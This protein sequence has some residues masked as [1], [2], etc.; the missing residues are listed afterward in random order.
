MDEPLRL[1]YTC[2]SAEK[3][4]AEGLL[5]LDQLGASKSSKLLSKIILIIIA[6][7]MLI[8]CYLKIYQDFPG[9]P[10]L[11][12]V[13][14]FLVWAIV[15]A[16]IAR[17]SVTRPP[18]IQVELSTDSVRINTLNGQGSVSWKAFNKVW[19]TE[20]LILLRHKD[21]VV[22]IF[23][24]RIFPDE[25]SL[26]WFREKSSAGILQSSSDE[27]MPIHTPVGLATPG[28][29][30]LQFKTSYRDYM[31]RTLASWRLRGICL[32]FLFIIGISFVS[33]ALNPSPAA[34][35]SPVQVFFYFMLPF[36][37]FAAVF[38]F[39]LF[40]TH[41][42]LRHRRAIRTQ[43]VIVAEKGFMCESS[44][45]HVAYSWDQPM[46]FKETPWSFLIWQS[47]TGFWLL[48][49][50]RVF[51]SSGSIDTCRKILCSR[52]KRSTWFF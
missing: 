12:G 17:K 32:L 20:N 8:G 24:T 22:Y 23:P 49:P 50:K 16:I 21:G 30:V 11:C 31:D 19:E 44:L 13:A 40:T 33:A 36:L 2:T 6:I 15:Y 26:E 38:G 41:D 5:I 28:D 10:I 45:G 47:G 1:E 51:Q 27:P 29:I 46:S 37:V 35:F 14:E 39:F 3:N 4:E 52:A 25:E 42:W 9:H 18:S 7:F 34:I 48:L 43:T